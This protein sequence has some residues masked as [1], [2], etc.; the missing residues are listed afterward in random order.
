MQQDSAL[1]QGETE[2]CATAAAAAQTFEVG[3]GQ[4]AGAGTV[5]VDSFRLVGKG[6]IT[7]DGGQVTL[8]GA[9]RRPLRP[10]VREIHS[11]QRDCVVN[12]ALA[13]RRLRFQL[14]ENGQTRRWV[15]FTVT[16]DAQGMAILSLLPAAQ[17]AEFGRTQAELLEFH[18][19]LAKVAPHA[20]VVPI[21]I[22]LNVL[23]FLAMCTQGMNILAPDGRFVLG[24]GSDFGPLTL[25]GQWWRTFT[26]LFVHFGLL[27]LGVNMW[28]LYQSGRIIER[29]FGS[30]RFLGLYVFSGLAG[31]LASLLWHPLVNSAG[32][33]G[34]IFGVL[35][36]LL[37]FVVRPGNKVPRQL[38][39][40]HRN[41]TAAFVLYSLFYGFAH[42]GIDNAA[43][44]GG[45]A[46]GFVM[47][48]L[49]SR[50]LDARARGDGGLRQAALALLV[51]T[52]MLAALAWPLANPSGSWQTSA[53]FQRSLEAFSDREKAAAD[54][55]NRLLG[56]GKA[57]SLSAPAFATALR[58]QV[59]PKWEDIY[60][61]VSAARLAPDNA[62][63]PLQQALLG[64]AD[65]RRQEYMAYADV[66]DGTGASTEA[67]QAKEHSKAALDTLNGLIAKR[68]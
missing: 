24:W 11:F 46:G 62:D 58:N 63:Y 45:L 40:E 59:A 3:F 22:G 56:Q 42:G 52:G 48:L 9:R 61:D 19:Q 25:G 34:A 7:V 17:T 30:L 13:G 6:T 18:R 41:S 27:H 14:S 54:L 43:H 8:S 16:S 28:V 5:A 26:S 66:I 1:A 39:N 38:V 2:T 51:G 55:F 12:A 49:L 10:N 20:F 67:D 35:G 32:A 15:T 44:L 47:G 50:P 57:G 31:S 36:G 60:R 23:V 4:R 33:S 65:A 68:K 64:Y 29:L 53:Q 21:L 37:A